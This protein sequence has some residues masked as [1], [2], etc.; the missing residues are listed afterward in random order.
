MRKAPVLYAAAVEI[1][2]FLFAESHCVTVAFELDG[3]CLAYNRAPVAQICDAEQCR[4]P[5]EVDA[6]T[7]RTYRERALIACQRQSTHRP[8]RSVYENFCRRIGCRIADDSA[9]IVLKQTEN[10][11]RI[12]V[13]REAMTVS[14]KHLYG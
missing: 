6:N 5:I 10:I 7:R 4:L 1:F 9:V 12:K 13:D 3:R 2:I 11:I 8:S 14:I